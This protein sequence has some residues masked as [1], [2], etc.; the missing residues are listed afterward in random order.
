MVRRLEEQGL[1]D[2]ADAEMETALRLDPDSWEVSKEAA[3]VRLRQKRL[4]EAA[5]LFE[6]AVSLMESDVHAWAMLVTCYHALGDG[7]A[8]RRAAEMSVAQAEHV[9]AQDPSNG[10]AMSFGA[11]GHAALGQ[12]HLA[13]EWMERAMLVDSDN[14]NMRYNF[15]SMLA[16]HLDDKDGA[17]RLLERY[18]FSIG[19]FQIGMAEGDPGLDSIRDDPEFQVMLGR[20][21]K[22]LGV[23]Q[24]P[25]E[26]S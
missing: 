6:K 3:R 19:A 22:R 4:P 2:L 8:E 25:I 20:A 21:K 1:Y 15:A 16:T 13:N 17:L 18:L 23:A 5:R 10:A 26:T 14:L 7:D 12:T 9:L 11:A 24:A